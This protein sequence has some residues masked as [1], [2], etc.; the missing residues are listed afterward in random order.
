MEESKSK[1]SGEKFTERMVLVFDVGT[2]SS[3]ALLVNNRGEIK[4]KATEK[5]DPPYI[6]PETDWAEQ[7][8]EFYYEK[9]CLAAQT[10]K[11]V[12]PVEWERIEAVSVTTIRDTALCVDREGKPLRNAFV[13]LDNRSAKGRPRFSKMAR[14]MLK[15][16]GMDKTADMQYRKSRCNWVM[17]NEPEIWEKTYK[18]LLISG[19]L[20]F[21][22][23]GNMTDSA[24]SMVG[25]VPFDHRERNWQKKGALTR[26]VFDIPPEKLCEIREPGSGLGCVQPD[27]AADTGLREG[28]PVIASGSDK[29]C[30]ILGLGCISR[31]KAAI[32]FG[33]TATVSFT[34]DRYVEPERFIPPY[35]A[36]LKQHYNPEIEIYRGYWLVSWFKKEFAQKEMAA[37]EELGIPAEELLNRRLKE[38]PAGCEGLILQP[39]FTPNTTMPSAKGAIIGFSDVHTRIHIYRAIIEGINFA[40]LDGMRLLEKQSGHSFQEI[41]VGGGGAQSNEICQI[42]ADMFGL[43]VKRVQSHEVSGIGSAIACFV[44]MGEFK[45]Y[46]EAVEQMVSVRDTFRPDME[47]HEI[48]RI[49][50]E[51]IFKKIYGRLSP[52]YAR[53]H[54]IYGKR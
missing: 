10:L 44:G 53:L 6:S 47:Q 40:L 3:R 22:L 26:P 17:E 46:E 23:T 32:S 21:R 37:A 34:T 36:I 25:H 16:I 5:H 45:N 50:Y 35:A 42:T 29:A 12:C 31:E 43:P 13:W 49:L 48:Y 9:I 24:A 27:A 20:I 11:S 8:A 41:F 28:L 30:E 54:E 7:K 52:L 1:V 33:T 19:Y 39:Y 14:V 18:F 38:I 4:A 2:Q 15:S 51:E